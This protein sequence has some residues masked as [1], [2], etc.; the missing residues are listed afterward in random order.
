MAGFI[1]ER[2]AGFI[3]ECLAGFIGIRNDN[4]S[5]LREKA[6]LR[7]IGLRSHSGMVQLSLPFNPIS[8]L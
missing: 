7:L 6:R 8:S 1:S 2:V 5:S 4:H 3:L